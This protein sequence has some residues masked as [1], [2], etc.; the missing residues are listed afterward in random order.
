LNRTYEE[1]LEVHDELA[2]NPTD[3]EVVIFVGVK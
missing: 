2:Q 1:D 3:V